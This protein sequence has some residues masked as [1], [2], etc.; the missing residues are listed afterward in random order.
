MQDDINEAMTLA[1]VATARID[2]HEHTCG[3]RYQRIQADTSEIK[4][5]LVDIGRK[6]EASTQRVHDR[7]DGVAAEG[8]ANANLALVAAQNAADGVKDAKIWALTGMGGGAL[9]I[10]AWALERVLG[11]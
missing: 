11:K 4:A 6:L 5:T 3:E 8:R 9:G 1:Q 10:A 2:A 7:V